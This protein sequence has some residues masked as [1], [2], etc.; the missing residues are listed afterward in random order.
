MTDNP[1]QGVRLEE[2]IDALNLTQT[3]LAESLGISQSYVSQMVGGSR[4][5]SRRV[6][7][8]I[9][10]N[11]PEINIRWLLTGEE[12]MFLEK[13]EVIPAPESGLLTGV[14]EPEVV[15]ERVRGEGRLEYLERVVGELLE[16]VR[17]LEERAGE[18]E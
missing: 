9:T 12:Q 5:I 3:S 1:E 2:I 11:Y 6:L 17:V 16:R 18:K 15:Y 13:K 8:F 7:H 10:K 4:N 14:M